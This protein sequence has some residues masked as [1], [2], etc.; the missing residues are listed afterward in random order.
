MH[1]RFWAED[2]IYT[3]SQGKR[4]GKNEIMQ[5]VRSAP[6]PKP[7]DPSSGLVPRVHA[8]PPGIDGEGDRRVQAYNFRLCLTQAADR[9]PFVKPEDYDP[10]EY[11]LMLRLFEMGVD[12]AG[13][14]PLPMPGGKSDSNNHGTA[15]TDWIGGSATSMASSI[16]ISSGS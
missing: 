12:A 6:A 8:G 10:L 15:S 3:G 5:D 7:G 9:V 14:D 2:V 11:E 13:L 4:R 1:D 16:A